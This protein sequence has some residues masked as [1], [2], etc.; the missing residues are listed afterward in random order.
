MLRG[1][2]AMEEAFR[3][4]PESAAGS[5]VDPALPFIRPN[6]VLVVSGAPIT[7]TVVSR[8]VA[9]TGLKCTVATPAEAEASASPENYAAVIIDEDAELA[10]RIATKMALSPDRRPHFVL[11][12]TRGP[13]FDAAGGTRLVD[14]VIAKPVTAECLQPMLFGLRGKD[15]DRSSPVPPLSL[16]PTERL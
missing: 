16:P 1:G 14:V 13:Q 5:P 7:A 4:V 15:V 11:L 6:H 12:A 9:M 10:G 8:I 3:T 2:M